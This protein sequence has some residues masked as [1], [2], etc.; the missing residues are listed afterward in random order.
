M[1]RGKAIQLI[2]VIN[3][4]KCSVAEYLPHGLSQSQ[5]LFE[6]H[7]KEDNGWYKATIKNV[8]ILT[9]SHFH[10]ELKFLQ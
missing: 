7:E 1:R 3:K 4:I 10:N 5:L 8:L 2:D 6:L 9:G